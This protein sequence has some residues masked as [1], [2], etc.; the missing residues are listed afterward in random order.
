MG[1]A[2]IPGFMGGL[3]T[4]CSLSMAR[5][6]SRF[7]KIIGRIFRCTYCMG[8]SP[9]QKRYNLVIYFVDWNNA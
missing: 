3:C 2:V 4:V 9:H 8:Y 7:H 1:K 5:L 6:A